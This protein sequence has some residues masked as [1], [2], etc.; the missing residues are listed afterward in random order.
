MNSTT[1][2]ET[3]DGHAIED[4]FRAGELHTE[5]KIEKKP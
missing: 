2:I 3:H 5:I 1:Q 4:Y